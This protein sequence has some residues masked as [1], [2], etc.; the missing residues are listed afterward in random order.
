MT[1]GTDITLSRSQKERR[2]TCVMD[3]SPHNK[4]V[5]VKDIMKV[6]KTPVSRRSLLKIGL[7][8]TAATALAGIDAVAWAPKRT[9]LAATNFPAIQFDLGSFLPP[10]QSFS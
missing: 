4:T 10:A 8:A 5:Q 6:E 3:V 7:T 9:A 1:I 2:R